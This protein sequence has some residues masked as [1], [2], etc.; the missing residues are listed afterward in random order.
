MYNQS[1]GDDY[2]HKEDDNLKQRIKDPL[3]AVVRWMKKRSPREKMVLM[4]MAAVM[5]L[6]LMW[7]VIE[8]HDNLF[9][10]AELVHFLGIG[11]LAWKLMKKKNA[12]GLSLRTQ[13]LTMVFLVVRLYCSFMM[14][15]DVHT[16][17]DM[18]TLLATAWVVYTLRFKLQD[19]YQDDQD[20]IK[21]YYVVVPCVALAALAHPGTNHPLAFR[22]LWALCVYLEAVSVLPQ[23]RMM[24]NA[25]VV[26]KFTAH[27][28]FAL[29]LSRFIS[30]AHWVLQI[31]DGDS[32]LL[33]AIGSGLWPAMVLLSEIVQTFILA[34]FCWYYIKSYAEGTG[35]IH[36]PAGIV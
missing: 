16:V 20:S 4:G 34:D 15:Y 28:V 13:E 29:G 1:Y 30:C 36:L 7:L 14:E 6:F 12:G 32:F 31:I 11:L 10:M 25:K 18:L 2:G 19:T 26:E 24:Q 33:Q 35:V 22:I 23:L 5:S 21:T 17:L 9:V 27:Y 8:D 3:L